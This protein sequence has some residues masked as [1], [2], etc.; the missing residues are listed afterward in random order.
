MKAMNLLVVAVAAFAFMGSA[1]GA[2][3]C[4]Q[5]VERFSECGGLDAKNVDVDSC[6]GVSECISKCINDSKCSDIASTD[7]NNPYNQCVAGC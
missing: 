6:D 2:N 3:D 7:P 4:E 1:C 5:A